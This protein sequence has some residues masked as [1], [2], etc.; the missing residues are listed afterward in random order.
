MDDAA[1]ESRRQPAATDRGPEDCIRCRYTPWARG[2]CA[3][4]YTAAWKAGTLTGKDGQQLGPGAPTA[5]ANCHEVKP[6]KSRGLCS[7][8]HM[9]AT[10]A[11]KLDELAAPSQRMRQEHTLEPA[12]A[13]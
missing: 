9:A 12:V 11:G 5:C 1:Y 2:L 7:R 10:R 3:S 6:I 4:H 13:A 8:C